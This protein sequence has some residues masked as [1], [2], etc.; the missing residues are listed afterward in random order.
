MGWT[1]VTIGKGATTSRVGERSGQ[2]GLPA[3]A[4]AAALA[5]VLAQAGNDEGDGC[6][7]VV[8][9]GAVRRTDDQARGVSS[10]GAND[11]RGNTGSSAVLGMCGQ[12]QAVDASGVEPEAAADFGM[13]EPMHFDLGHAAQQ[14][15][16][17]RRGITE[18]DD[19]P[20][21]RIG[22]SNALF[23]PR[24]TPAE[25]SDTHPRGCWARHQPV[26]H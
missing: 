9:C 10:I 20:G 15:Q 13:R 6:V 3:A 2:L 17:R 16:L 25:L 8:H 14:T 12:Q 22:F 19:A 7:G 1:D 4:A 21:Q 24:N 26:E 23:P 5:L 11:R 18:V